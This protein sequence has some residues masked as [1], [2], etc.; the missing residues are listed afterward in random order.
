[1]AWRETVILF[2]TRDYISFV[3]FPGDYKAGGKENRMEALLLHRLRAA[4]FQHL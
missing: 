3:H 1:M 2:P 4:L